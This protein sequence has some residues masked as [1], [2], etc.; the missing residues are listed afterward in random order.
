M[1]FGR[2]KNRRKIDLAER[3]ATL[4]P[5]ALRVL[6]V[7]A[8]AAALVASAYFG[9]GWALTSPTFA[10][11]TLSFHG[12][13][14]ATEGE[15]TR[16]SGLAAGQNL[17]QL[18]LPGL[19]KAMSAHPW[20]RSVDL[21]RQLPNALV[22]VVS[23]H[24][25]V[26][27]VSLGDLYLLDREGEPFKKVQPGEGVDLPLISGL[28]RDAYVADPQKSA[29]RLRDALGMIS[30]YEASDRAAGPKLSEVRLE[31][32]GFTLITARGVEV[33]LGAGETADQLARLTRVAAELSH[34][35]LTA[36]VIRLD[37]RV[38][39]G[40]VTVTVSKHP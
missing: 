9:H 22:V 14:R 8:C 40:W 36:E 34:R 11:H 26:A 4:A 30:A 33:H 1:A 39:P 12:Q 23:E 31:S 7:L 29:A 24:E 28:D 25:P 6:A 16:L 3:T 20:I 17:F 35:G 18:D 37:N 38:R 21:R 27:M 10:L 5:K 19:A 2:A 15:L 32:D 13:S